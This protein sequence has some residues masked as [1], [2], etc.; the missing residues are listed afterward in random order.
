VARSEKLEDYLDQVEGAVSAASMTEGVSHEEW[1][2]FL[3]DIRD[4]M[5]SWL[6]A[7]DD[8]IAARAGHTSTDAQSGE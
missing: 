5:D 3:E 6:E 7:L 4:A 2:A 8:Q 1:R